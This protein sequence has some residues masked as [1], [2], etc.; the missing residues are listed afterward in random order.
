MEIQTSKPNDEL[1]IGL[2]QS[3]L[4][5]WTGQEMNPDAPLYNM[6]LVFDLKGEI[7]IQAFKAAF[8]KIVDNSDAMRTVFTVEG[9]GPRQQV[10]SEFPYELEIL[11]WSGLN[12]PNAKFQLW[13]K[14]RSQKKLDLSTCCFDSALVK[15]SNVHYAWL[16]N[17]HHLITDAWAVSVLYKA[18]IDYYALAL[19]DDLG[20]A[21]VLPQFSDYI[22]FER[23]AKQD[24]AKSDA[25]EYW[26]KRLSQL[27]E[28]PKL[29]GNKNNS[30]TSRTNRLLLDLGPERSE[31][32]RALTKEP[33]LRAWTEH[34]SLFNIFT[35]ALFAFLYRTS[36]QKQLSIGTPAHNRPTA[37]FKNSPGVFIEIFPLIAGIEENESFSSLIQKV[38]T[39][40]N[41]FLRFA[42]PGASS[43]ELNRNFNVILNYIHAEFSDFGN[44]P[45]QSEW[46]HPDHCDPRHHLRMQVHDFDASGNIQLYFDLNIDVFND[47]IQQK[48]PQ[49]F[50]NILDAIIENRKQKIAD[51]AVVTSEDIHDINNWNSGHEKI[52]SVPNVVELF[53]AQTH[54]QVNR[55]VIIEKNNE[56]TYGMLNESANQ[57]AH[58]LLANGL[59]Q[60]DRVALFLKRSSDFLVSV[61]G[62]LKAGGVYVPIASNY[63]QE[64]VAYMLDNCGA[65]MVITHKGL[66]SKIKKSSYRV[67]HLGEDEGFIRQQKS[68][69][70]GV[71]AESD[72]LAYIMYTSGSTGKP[73]GVMISHDS[74]ANY[75]S[76][77]AD[78]YN[79]VENSAYPLFTMIGFDLTVTSIFAPLVSGG[80][81]VVYEESDTG[82]DLSIME[83]IRENA[84]DIIKLT[85][86]HLALIKDLDLT[87]SR[88]KAMIVGGEDFKSDLAKSVNNAFGGGIDIYNEYG[89]TEATVG[90]VLY[91]YNPMI[92]TGVSVPIGT[93]TSG[94]KALV[95][96]EQQQ[97]TPQGVPGELYIAGLGL[98]G[99]Y[100]ENEEL[101]TKSFI[102]NPFEKGQKLYKT[103][104]LV[105]LNEKG[106]LEYLG[107]KDQQ[108]K[109]GGIRI[110]L[111]EIE[112][113]LAA[114][115]LIGET[116][117]TLKEKQ[118]RLADEDIQ[119]C[120]KCGLPSNYP[121]AQ[122]DDEGVC[123]LCNSFESYQKKARQY[124]KTMDDLKSL[125]Q[126]SKAKR[127]GEYDCM[128]LL[129]GG[130]D[131]TYAMAQLV[132]MGLKVL[133]FTLDNGYISEQALDN[134]RRVTNELGVD[135]V[136]G[137]TDAM[138]TIFVDSLHR[139]SNVC[140]G[141][142]KTIYTLSTKIALEKGIPYIVTGLSRGQFFETRLTE[143][144]F[145]SDEVDVDRIDQIILNA[146]KVYHRVD[147][148]VCQTLDVSMYETDE[149]FEKVQFLDFYR[150]TDV[151]L[152]EMLDYLDNRLPW[153]R[154][155]DT[156]RSTNC[157]I[158]QVGIY[159]HKN[160][161][162][163]NNYAFPYSWDVRIG[164]KSRDAALE[165]INEEVDEVEVK[166]IMEEIG[167]TLTPRSKD[168]N[169][170]LVAYYIGEQSI[171]SKEIRTFLANHLPD[172][173]VPSH[174]IRLSEMPLS[175]NGKIDR[176][177]LPEPGG[178]RSESSVEYV[179]PENEIEE[180]LE[181]IWSEVL[182][183]QKIGI[184]DNFL[185]LG[186]HSLAAI[187]LIARI[188]EAF[189]LELQLNKV[190]EFPTIRQLAA[191]IEETIMELLGELEG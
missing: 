186:G 2:T 139:H 43:A 15:F 108:V 142:F 37:D 100:W 84:V 48:V 10:L 85:P 57:L 165:E 56:F 86:S 32:L 16:F 19:K 23:D 12:H 41:G 7:D 138:N 191:H 83:V 110:E 143:E 62:V 189:E 137:K 54:K 181:G 103:G 45:M 76:W 140:N 114:H 112:S 20:K 179:A 90:C 163:Y 162:G 135:L 121:D 80:R 59:N 168:N 178:N 14:E 81:I 47:R 149:V 82:A 75:A 5:M 136:I 164:H 28:S 171:P 170:S 53:E 9:E 67:I 188:N 160:D 34:L 35:T 134:V 50:L 94:M 153:V 3:Q 51:P 132:E 145:W 93:P 31:K 126:A 116:V 6:V 150:Y 176:S 133:A 141:C 55:I 157:L 111:G 92:D 123:H 79:R 70:P 46:I 21:Y 184:H 118:F 8:K 63:P 26:K 151:H 99:G 18:M 155:S 182:Q 125:F 91:K 66:S 144:L 98:A 105:R 33:D 73:K 61:M 17:Q 172:Y 187:R 113:A 13:A 130:K 88:I 11:D 174:F 156:G 154:P 183:L 68:V 115:P 69:N 29:Y 185:D 117:V 180:M 65:S 127:Q 106:Q 175:P 72:D 64:R 124:F 96:N 190:F 4:L 36:G 44:M 173:M 87:D 49:H 95:L 102:A 42:Q 146:R 147:D 52:I 122:Y 101:T 148:A 38:K 1:A 177:K 119:Y 159:V 77:A 39:E 120:V 74:L 152:D 71:Q 30:G 104:D 161:K 129:S 24:P 158:N 40:T 89:P 107:R 25:R 58:Y 166:R 27:P 131:S 109:I 128:S 78:T 167:Y 22:S 169:Q 60:G 97:L